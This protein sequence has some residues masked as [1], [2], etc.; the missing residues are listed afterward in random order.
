MPAVNPYVNTPTP[1]KMRKIVKTL[2]AGDN[3][4]VS[5]YPTVARVVTVI[6]SESK[7]F[8]PSIS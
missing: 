7:K 2:P 3:G 4:W 5:P 6:K 8:Q 1:T